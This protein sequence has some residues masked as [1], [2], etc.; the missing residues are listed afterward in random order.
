MKNYYL[1][2]L[3]A[4]LTGILTLP[5]F[6]AFFSLFP[7]CKVWVREHDAIV[8]V[9][10]AMFSIIFLSG[11]VAFWAKKQRYNLLSSDSFIITDM[12]KGKV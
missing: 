5:A 4:L 3:S 6:I 1:L 7:E 8:W 12:S 10:A 9:M 11:I 2:E